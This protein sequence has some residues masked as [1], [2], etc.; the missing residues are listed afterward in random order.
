MSLKIAGLNVPRRLPATE[1]RQARQTP[2]S[3]DSAPRQG[4]TRDAQF[5]GLPD[6]ALPSA[7]AGQSLRRRAQL[8]TRGD[9]PAPKRARRGEPEHGGGG[10]HPGF[11]PTDMQQMMR[12]QQ[13]MMLDTTN[14]QNQMTV[15]QTACKLIEQ[16]PKAARDLIQ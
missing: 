16:G 13:Q 15:T 8:P 10:N 12:Q 9:Q 4:R 2:A 1:G 6:L 14:A 11:S 7:T 5:G 3:G